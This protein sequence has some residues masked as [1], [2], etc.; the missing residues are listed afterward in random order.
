VTGSGTDS[1]WLFDS[2]QYIDFTEE[3]FI[4]EAIT[5][6]LITMGAIG[7]SELKNMSFKSYEIAIKECIK[8]NNKPAPVE[9]TEGE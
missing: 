5:A 8:A 3:I 1:L 2:L 6:S 7:F 9:Q 4:Q